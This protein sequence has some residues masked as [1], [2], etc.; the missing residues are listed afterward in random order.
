MVLSG[1]VDM[2]DAIE[3]ICNHLSARTATLFLGQKINC[4]SFNNEEARFPSDEEICRLICQ[5]LLGS[6]EPTISLDEAVS[7]ARYK[8][9]K[10]DFNNFLYD[11]LWN[12]IPSLEHFAL[13]ELPWDVIYT[14]N[15]DLLLETAAK[16][17]TIKP[18]GTIKTVCSREVELVNFSE[19][20]IP[21]YKLYGSIDYANTEEGKLILSQE[22]RRYY[23]T[24]RRSLFRRLETRYLNRSF[25][26]LGYSIDDA[27]FKL[28]L[29]D[30]RNELGNRA[31]PGSFAIL[32]NFTEIQAIYWKDRYNI[33]L[34]K[35]QLNQFINNLKEAWFAQNCSVIPFEERKTKKYL[36]VDNTTR[37]PR[38]GDS[39]YLIQPSECVVQSNPKLFFL[40]AEPSWSDIRD[41]IPPPRDAYWTIIETLF[42]ELST[43]N[44][45]SSAYLITGAAGTGKTTLIYS[46]AYML[47]KD[48]SLPVVMHIPGTTLNPSSLNQLVDDNHLKRIIVIIRSAAEYIK[49]IERFVEEIKKRNL[50]VTIFLEERKNQWKVASGALRTN[51]TPI[52]FE[53]AALSNKEVSSILDALTKHDALGK[54]KGSSREYQE[55]HFTDIA[56]KE[57]LVA[58]RELTSQTSFDA[59]VKDEFEKIPSEVAKQAYVHVAALG[60]IDLTIRYETLTHLL[61]LRYDQLGK[62]VF[63]PTE[64]V[65]VTCE[66][67]GSSRHNA[68][69]RLGTRHPIIASIIFAIA[70]PDDDAK[71]KVL[72]GLLTQLDPGFNEDN[73]LLTVISRK[74]ELVNVF[75]SKEKR[76]AIYERLETILPRNPFVLQHRS[77]LERELENAALA[78]KYARKA[79]ALDKQNPTILHT[80]GMALEFAARFDNDPMRQDTLLLEASK[81]FEDGIKRDPSNPYGYI[82]KFN[83]LR[84]SIS[85]AS[86]EEKRIL[87][88]ANALALLEEAYEI[89][90][91]STIIAVKLAN[92]KD[93]LSDPESAIVVLKSALEKNSSDTRIRDLLIRFYIKKGD[94]LDALKIAMD[95]EKLDPTS[96]RLQRHIARL[97]KNLDKP[98]DAIKGHYEA[99]IRHNKGD[100]SLMVELGAYL[101]INS[102]YE[103]AEEIFKETRNLP[104]SI[105]EKWK[106][107][108]WWKDRNDNKQRFTGKVNSIK[109]GIAFAIAIPQNFHARFSRNDALVSDIIE[110][111]SISFHVGFNVF[112]PS[113]Q[114]IDLLSRK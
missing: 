51:L 100:L 13:V 71:F 91:E 61:D 15:Y 18:A 5:E 29:D 41:S 54:L 105:Q 92:Q 114:N 69:F 34:I 12:F 82:G 96:W 42:P 46:V 3:T 65:L 50:P 108:E 16:T 8:I 90:D 72:N 97:Q 33:Q 37:F 57:L 19:E 35:A 98:F 30:C 38:V 107:R 93:K 77:I 44:L 31:F 49:Q 73:R 27:S 2:L 95:G 81:L 10:S 113:A 109:G 56:H 4:N 85:K 83:I 112:G 58:L 36:Q 104:S 25:I 106:I 43:P 89:T 28:T 11:K 88:E 22:D 55:E 111:T 78:V 84:Q 80:L 103:D 1:G 102:R 64:G 99:A 67:S 62:E 59:I 45:S 52:E 94:L 75:S 21:Y 60:Q 9:G 17:E 14:T 66:E 48:F 26:F 32:E 63:N 87:L 101:F 23:E 6:S 110:G 86:D 74:R 79:V 53:L 20:D 68:G 39:F 47:A 7:M 24:N 70:A 76:R 40:G